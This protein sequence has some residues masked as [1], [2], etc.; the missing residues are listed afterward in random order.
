MDVNAY[1]GEWFPATPAAITS[2]TITLL[3]GSNFVAGTKA[4]LYGV[5]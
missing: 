3:S 5:Q 2:I 4:T 1:S